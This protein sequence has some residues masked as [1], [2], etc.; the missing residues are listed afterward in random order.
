MSKP[1]GVYATTRRRGKQGTI[2]KLT[3]TTADPKTGI[4]TDVVSTTTVRWMVKEPTAHSRIIRAEAVQTQIGETTFVCWTKDAT[5][6]ALIAAGGV[7][8]EDWV[9]FEGRRYEVV[10]STVEDTGLI[11][12]ARETVK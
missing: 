10:S 7:D 1:D 5:V 12:T 4:R 2:N 8:Q 9:T 3:G 6:A 11:I